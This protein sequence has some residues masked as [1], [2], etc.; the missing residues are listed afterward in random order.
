MFFEKGGR[1]YWF[2][3]FLREDG[4]EPVVICCNAKH[5]SN[6]EEYF[7][8]NERKYI[9]K[10][11]EEI[12]VP[13]IFVKSRPYSTN[14]KDRILN[15]ID[16]YRNLLKVYKELSEIYGKPDII[17]ASSVH[18]LT[19]WAGIKIAKY[20]GI[21]CICEIRDLWPESIIAYGMI[22]QNSMIAKSLRYFEKKIYIKADAIV[23]TMEGGYDYIVEQGW[24]HVI[25][26]SKTYYINNG[27]DLTAFDDNKKKYEFTDKDLDNQEFFNIVYTGSIRKVNNLG[28]VLDV[29]KKVKNPSVRFLIWGDGD[30]LEKLQERVRKEEV[31]NVIFKGRV[32]KIYI[33]AITS[34]ASMNYAHN[35]QS[36][37][38]YYGISF[39]KMFEY[40]AAGKPVLCDFASKYNP[41]LQEKAG[42][43]VEEGSVEKI[44]QAIDQ[45]TNLSKEELAY[46][47]RNARTA[48]QKYDFKELTSSLIKVI[49]TI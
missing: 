4:Y 19:L 31:H 18:P 9:D 7:E 33:P 35:G 42:I 45:F 30:E 22:G 37:M 6:S 11:A 27:V 34:K 25:S 36:Q 15:M 20:Y 43:T 41:V 3:R 16:F 44:A 5:N 1:H 28:I 8:I 39:N 12:S 17:Y 38:L 23:F 2:A 32:E 21:K 46:Y 24:N 13:F 29:A 10:N 47:G 49:E 48:S 14:G 40:L 26:K